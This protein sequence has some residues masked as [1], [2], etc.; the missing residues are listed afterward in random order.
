METTKD[1]ELAYL[2]IFDNKCNKTCE[3]AKRAAEKAFQNIAKREAEK[4]FQNIK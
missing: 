3:I 4:A 1:C 2:C